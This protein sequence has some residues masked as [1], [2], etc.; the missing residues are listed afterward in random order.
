M[1]SERTVTITD[2]DVRFVEHAKADYEVFAD[3]LDRQGHAKS[4]GAMR[5]QIFYAERFLLRLTTEASDER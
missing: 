5:K 2:D 1:A 3:A 4:A